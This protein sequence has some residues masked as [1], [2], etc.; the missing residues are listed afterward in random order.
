MYSVCLPSGFPLGA[1][2]SGF[3][4]FKCQEYS[5]P[6]PWGKLL[7]GVHSLRLSE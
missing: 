5:P 6:S 7:S 3:D 4:A 2:V 1:L